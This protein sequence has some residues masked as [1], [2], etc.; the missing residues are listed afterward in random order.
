M[1]NNK[2]LLIWA[3]DIS[4][5]SG[6]GILARTFFNEIQKIKKFKNIKIKTFESNDNIKNLNIDKIKFKEVNKNTIYHK[7]F[8][9]I[10]GAIYL[11]FFSSKSEILYLNYLPLWN[12]VIFLILPKKT[13]LGPITGGIYN[14]RINNLNLFVRKYFFPIFYRISKIIIYKKFKKIILSTNNLNRFVKND[15]STLVNFIEILFKKKIYILNK[16]KKY[17]IIFYNRNHSMK[18]SEDIKKTILYLSKYC[19]IC[20]VGDNFKSSN[21]ENFGWLER[22]Q[23]FKLIQKSKFAFNS[24][25]NFLSI[26]GID[27][28]NNGTPV[29]YD[30]NIKSILKE[31]DF[32]YIPVN[33]NN[34]KAASVQI[35]GLIKNKVV[36]R[37]D[38]KW[39]NDT[40]LKKKRIRNFLLLYLFR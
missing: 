15:N 8:G 3:S 9:P 28:I 5:S 39:W 33:F 29:I 30:K 21:I 4:P 16:K 19:K 7:Y 27:C 38:L 20:V 13:I 23:V 12:F 22:D 18:F 25:E 17:D 14:G 40:L 36:K 34:I 37:A 35:L 10:Y 26:F 1:T 32:N 31:T 2:N 24:A 6:E 11:R